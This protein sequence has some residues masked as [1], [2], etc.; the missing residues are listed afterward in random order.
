MAQFGEILNEFKKLAL[1][2]SENIFPLMGDNTL[3]NGLIAWKSV[4]ITFDAL[5]DCPF[6]DDVQR[7]DWLWS[8]VKFDLSQ[9]A[10]VSGVKIHDAGSL[11]TRLKSLRLIYPDGTINVLAKQY[12]QS[13]ILA[14][15]NT[16]NTKKSK[17]EV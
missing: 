1:G 10:V 13:Q 7:W 12:L 17:S 14:K 15:I 11:F 6:S 9:F 2:D 3:I 5:E 4:G 16:K 8:K